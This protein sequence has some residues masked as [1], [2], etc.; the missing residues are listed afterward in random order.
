MN[1][2]MIWYMIATEGSVPANINPDIIPGSETRPMVLAE[3]RVGCMP[4]LMVSLMI[5]LVACFGVAPNDN[6]SRICWF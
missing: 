2:T 6:F 4:N 3:S 5:A 1:V